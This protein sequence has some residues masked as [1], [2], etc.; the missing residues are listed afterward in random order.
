MNKRQDRKYQ[1][2]LITQL[3]MSD[4]TGSEIIALELAEYFSERARS[5][6]IATSS[7]EE[8]MR[9]QVQKLTNVKVFGVNDEE[10]NR[11]IVKEGVDI[12]WI[13]HQI[14]PDALLD[15]PGD[16]RFIFHHMSPFAEQEA[17]FAYEV[18]KAFADN[19]L[20]NSE[21][22]QNTFRERGLFAE[23][24]NVGVLY[25]PAPESFNIEQPIGDKLK[26]LLIV[27]NHIPAEINSSIEL[28]KER[29]VEVTVFSVRQGDDSKYQRVTA[30]TLN[31]YDAVISIGKTVQYALLGRMPVYCYDRFGGPGYLST[32]NFSKACKLN[33]SGRGFSQKTATE[34]VD[35]L[36]GGYHD[37]KQSINAIYEKNHKKFSL[38]SQLEA[39]L[40]SDK[41]VAKAKLP[42]ASRVAYISL[43]NL[44]SE[45][46]PSIRHMENLKSKLEKADKQI[47]DLKRRIAELN[48][49]RWAYDDISKSDSYR[50]GK[51][52]LS[53]L[54]YLKQVY[55]IIRHKIGLIKNR[56]RMLRQLDGIYGVRP[57]QNDAVIVDLVIRNYLHPT[58]STFIR[59]VSPLLD[60]SFGGKIAY[61]F[62]D[63]D[64]PKMS[65]NPSVVIVQR[66]ALAHTDDAKKLV[67]SV[68][69]A[70]AKLFVDTDDAFG[71]LDRS[72]PQFAI[73]RERVDALNY[74][75]EHADEVWFSTA[76]LQS[77]YD[78]KKS[79]VIRNTIDM[80]LWDR[81]RQNKVAIPKN[82]EPLQLLYM[83][84]NTHDGDFRIIEPALTRLYEKYPGEFVF[85]IIGVTDK[86]DYPWLVVHQPENSLYPFFVEWFN[87]MRPIDVGVSPLDDTPFN[88]NKSD[89]KCLD[90]LALGVMP[91]VSD[92][93][94][95]SNPE[96]DGLI[97]RVKNST[98]AWL[99]ALET[100]LVNREANRKRAKGR[101]LRG[102][103]YIA[104]QRT[105]AGAARE[106]AKSIG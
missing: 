4:F 100:E 66:T 103:D 17:P 86:A 84:T 25:N 29:G 39:V 68:R 60:Q 48:E 71:Q 58:S 21:E 61:K 93:E 6:Y 14:I 55:N 49:Y 35:E 12:A 8:P 43:R 90:Y 30:G 80:R 5:V 34:I 42:A 50:L 22:T 87:R 16:T 82:D 53:P 89:I 96:L 83:G 99:N 62:V 10:L 9:T 26:K 11:L 81:L 47:D 24:N 79:K 19:I 65:R 37:A 44:T 101:I 52:I 40:T 13:H 74:V 102:Y 18:E 28:L 91:M 33:F 97:K 98:E 57:P 38:P 95:Y 7:Y 70:G 23:L 72:H 32:Q 45:K 94:A 51:L 46:A 67:K 36:I 88:E 76:K 104:S 15:N 69:R 56:K 77:L 31:G 85:H 54:R 27:S 63:G 20:C 106:L 75:M 59:L 73:Q 64:N 3:R 105:T 41:Q 2:V 1:N 92:V 78:V